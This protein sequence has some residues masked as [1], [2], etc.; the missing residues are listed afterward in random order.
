M[1]GVITKALYVWVSDANDIIKEFFE[2]F[3]NNYQEELKIICGSEF[4]FENV[5][6]MHCKL[7]QVHLGET[8]HT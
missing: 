2:S 3:L 8:D 7:P 5:E 4:N 6:L 1:Y